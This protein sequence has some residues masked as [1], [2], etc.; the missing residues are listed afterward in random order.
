MVQNKK[1]AGCLLVIIGI[2]VTC[3]IYA[4]IPLYP[5]IST[6]FQ[7]SIQEVALGSTFFT[8]FYACGLLFFGPLSDNFGHRRIILSGLVLSS[9][10]TFFVATATEPSSLYIFRSLQGFTLASFAPVAF[11]YAFE[12]YTGTIR[13]FWI[14]LIN[15]GFLAAGIIGQLLSGW[16]VLYWSWANTYLFYSCIY[17]FLFF[18][19]LIILPKIN[20]NSKKE[21]AKKIINGLYTALKKTTLFP[22]YLIVITILFSFVAFY[23]TFSYQFVEANE[24]MLWIRSLGITGVVLSIFTGKIIAKISAIKTLKFGISLICCSIFLILLMS[25]SIF[26]FG[27]FSIFFVGGIS[28]L[29]PTLIHLIGENSGNLRA[30][31]ISLYSFILL[32]GASIG[33][34]VASL[35]PYKIVLTMILALFFINYIISHFANQKGEKKKSI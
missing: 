4:L 9:I 28:I 10:T 30:K 13:T 21:P 17:L 34:V 22:L 5:A 26:I 27:I 29:I 32:I 2:M 8:F 3:N 15:A 31:A 1:L 12:I 6:E 35:F 33:P 20:Q 11:S 19:A 25:N 24:Q 7:I 18:S 14:A 23:E 16:I